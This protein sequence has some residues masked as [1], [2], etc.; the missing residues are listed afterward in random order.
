[1]RARAARAVRTTF[2]ALRNRN[3]RLYFAG[4]LVSQAGTWLTTIALTLLVL[5]L[6]HSGVAIGLLTAAQFGP[7]LLFGAWGGLVAD[8]TDKHRLLIITQTL[9]MLQSFVLAVLAFMSNPP[10]AAFY[11]TALAGGFMLAFDNPA[12]R[13]FVAEMVEEDD[14][15]NAVTLNTALMTCSRVIGPALAGLLVATT[16][17]AWCFLIDGISYLAVIASLLMMRRSE[18]RQPPVVAR[19]R[20]Q[21]R[22]AL[23][24]IHGASDLWIPLAMMTVVGT[25]TFNFSVV[26]PL[27]VEDTF[28]ASAEAFTLLFSVLSIGSLMGALIA[29]HMRVIDTRHV[30][31]A[32]ISFGL[33]MALLAAAPTLGIA[34][35]LA[36]F[37]GLTSVAFITTATATVQVRSDPA[38]RGRVLALQ[39]MLLVGTTPIGGPLLG[40]FCDAYGARAGILLGAVAALAAGAWGFRAVRRAGVRADVDAGQIGV[41]VPG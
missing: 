19:A 32:A 26:M 1:V 30:A 5:S 39:A 16:G 15:Q 23:R 41:G 36:V 29:S 2:R 11:V 31:G 14:I 37:V 4:Q 18:L 27:F 17:F 34:F 24:Y 21:L 40:W 33:A 8:R 35:P 9:E 20:G 7:I 22:A 28:N 10:I 6:T 3:F 13:S 38:M 12:R 25:L